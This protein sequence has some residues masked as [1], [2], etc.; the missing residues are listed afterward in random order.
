MVSLKQQTMIFCLLADKQ[1]KHKICLSNGER[2][3]SSRY[4]YERLI[5]QVRQQSTCLLTA[6]IGFIVIVNHAQT[7][8]TS[9]SS[10]NVNTYVRLTTWIVEWHSSS[11]YTHACARTHIDMNTKWRI[12]QTKCR[13]VAAYARYIVS[14][15]TILFYFFILFLISKA[16]ES[17]NWIHNRA[18]HYFHFQ[19]YKFITNSAMYHLSLQQI[20]LSV[21]SSMSVQIPSIYHISE[22]SCATTTIATPM[23]FLLERSTP[24]V[25]RGV[26][27]LAFA[28]SKPKWPYQRKSRFKSPLENGSLN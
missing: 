9:A 19:N 1:L 17:H 22:V 18:F 14:S 7:L 6:N 28:Y 10:I 5:M 2:T 27:N 25:C 13:S 20:S 4:V 11:C 21:H 26:K 12:N 23:S 24:L 3:P 15:N 16:S 8:A